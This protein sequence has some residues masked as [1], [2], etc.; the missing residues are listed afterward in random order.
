MAQPVDMNN[1]FL[2]PRDILSEAE[3]KVFDQF[4]DNKAELTRRFKWWSLHDIMAYFHSGL[5]PK[6]NNANMFSFK[7]DLTS[8]EISANKNRNPGLKLGLDTAMNNLN[9]VTNGLVK[10]FTDVQKEAS[11]TQAQI[12]MRSPI[13]PQAQVTGGGRKKKNNSK[14]GAIDIGAK[15]TPEFLKNECLK[16]LLLDNF[17]SRDR[18]FITDGNLPNVTDQLKNQ[19]AEPDPTVPVVVAAVK[20]GRRKTRK[21]RKSYKKSKTHRR[22]RH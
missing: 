6:E 2:I 5:M 18:I 1:P 10:D 19:I 17:N 3:Q 22:R 9:V 4:K 13:I 20:G 7:I 14:G 11:Q 15:Y 8:D 12:A 21:G 16:D